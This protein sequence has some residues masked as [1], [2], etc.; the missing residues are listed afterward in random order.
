MTSARFKIVYFICIGLP[1]LSLFLNIISWLRFGLDLPF[2]DDWRG[3]ASG[4]IHSLEIRYL[5]RP[6]NDTLAPV[7]FAFDALA[8]RYLDGNSVAYQFLSLLIILGGLL[9]L[10]WRLLVQTIGNSLLTPLCFLL[11]LLML[12]PGSYWGREN[13]AY[14]QALPLIFILS[15]LTLLLSPTAKNFWRMPL[16]FLFSLLAGFSYISGAFGVLAVGIGLLTA[17][18]VTKSWTDRST[19][20]LGGVI[21]SLSGLFS[22]TVQYMVAIPKGVTHRQDAPMAM[23]YELDFWMFYLGKLGRSLLLPQNRPL[24]SSVITGFIIFL[25]IFLFFIFIYKSSKRTTLSEVYLRTSTVFIAISSV[26]FVYLLLV[27]AGRTNLRPSEVETSLQVFSYGYF[28]FHFF[29]A[30]LLWPWL[31]AMVVVTFQEIR[32]SIKFPIN[33][34]IFGFISIFVLFSIRSGAFDHSQQYRAETFFRKPT[35]ACLFEQLQKGGPIFCNEFNMAD[36]RTAYDYGT[37]NGASFV[38]HFPILPTPLGSDEPSP[39]FR[40]S[41]DK[42]ITSFENFTSIEFNPLSGKTNN[43]SQIIIQ[44]PSSVDL[45]HCAILDLSANL[46]IEHSDVAQIF[47]TKPNDITFDEN[48]SEKIDLAFENRYYNKIHI[49]LSSPDGFGNLFR[50]DPA[51]SINLINIQEIELRCKWLITN[52]K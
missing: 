10:Q 2:F 14:H 1:L 46:M 7:G 50:F 20:M 30:T 52:I 49:R 19:L 48:K 3:Y 31:A 33:T 17:C 15:S 27:A 9:L 11:T 41:R 43:D 26:V 51:A 34:L 36:F 12:Q 13:L 23:P 38:K 37:K 8:Q 42:S 47:Y 44:L 5:F 6:V 45:S 18:V 16:I 4:Q 40:L 29:W 25:I 24:F 21:L 35:I 39:V 28:R 32:P 22:S